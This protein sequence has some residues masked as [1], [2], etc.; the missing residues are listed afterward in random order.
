MR[1][2]NR[3]D[4]LNKGEKCPKCLNINVNFLDM[5][6]SCL[7][8][9]RCGCMFVRKS[10]LDSIDQKALLEKQRIEDEGFLCRVG[11]CSHKIPF[12]TKAGLM[13]HQ[14]GGKCGVK[15]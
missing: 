2:A 6:E 10:L 15:D 5:G 7:S 9:L 3:F 14:R 4:A 1:I 12:K 11:G 8:C 13:A